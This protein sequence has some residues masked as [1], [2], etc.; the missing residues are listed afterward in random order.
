MA[1]WA[2]LDEN[3]IVLRVTVG[4]N[5]DPNGDEGYQWLIDNLGGRWI[6]TSYNNNFRKRFAGIGMK[7]YEDLDAFGPVEPPYPSWV[8]DKEEVMFV[9]P[10]PMP[11]LVEG[12]YWVWN[13]DIINWELFSFEEHNESSSL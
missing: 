8:F 13:E 11:A 10:V 6:Q 7:Y 3:N 12:S 9:S 4:D 1:H 5:D 2:E